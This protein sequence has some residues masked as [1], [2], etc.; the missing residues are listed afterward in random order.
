MLGDP[1]LGPPPGKE[2]HL[3]PPPAASPVPRLASAVTSGAVPRGRR[4]SGRRLSRPALIFDGV[5]SL[6]SETEKRGHYTR[7]IRCTGL[8]GEL[9]AVRAPRRLTGP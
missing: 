9:L 1:W 5:E 4:A 6:S 8:F 3:C 7:V 2:G